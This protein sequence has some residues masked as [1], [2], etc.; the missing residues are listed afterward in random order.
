MT[1]MEIESSEVQLSSPDLSTGEPYSAMTNLNGRL[2]MLH[3]VL[4]SPTV[5]LDFSGHSDL[6]LM[7][8][9]NEGGHN[10]EGRRDI[11]QF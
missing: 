8:T 4:P 11:W 7:P 3:A 5:M 1:V 10:G 2:A 6:R 9:L